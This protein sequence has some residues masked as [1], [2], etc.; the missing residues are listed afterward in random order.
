[1]QK[2]NKAVTKLKEIRKKNQQLT[3]S[4]RFHSYYINKC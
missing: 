1:M 4:L 2:N 3:G